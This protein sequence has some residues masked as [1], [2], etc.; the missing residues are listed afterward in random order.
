[1]SMTEDMP[2]FV[3]EPPG[4]GW[5]VAAWLAFAMA[6]LIAGLVLMKQTHDWLEVVAMMGGAL[7]VFVVGALGLVFGLFGA[8]ASSTVG[9]RRLI[10]MLPVWANAALL[11]GFVAAVLAPR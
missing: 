9:D 3:G 8:A 2:Q 7:L 10:V 6:G 11:I 1:M 4:T 5:R